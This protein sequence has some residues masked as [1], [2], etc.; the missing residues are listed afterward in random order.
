MQDGR[1]ISIL[2]CHTIYKNSNITFSWEEN[3]GEELLQIKFL[4][5]EKMIT[6]QAVRLT[7][8]DS[9]Q[10]CMWGTNV[11]EEHTVSICMKAAE[12]VSTYETSRYHNPDCLWLK[13]ELVVCSP[14]TQKT[15]IWTSPSRKFWILII[16]FGVHIPQPKRW[17]IDENRWKYMQ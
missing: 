6:L 3:L 11:L 7:G 2:N 4:H 1:K 9:M 15:T 5:T 14:K 13:T 17:K 16:L 12:M 10:S 8:C